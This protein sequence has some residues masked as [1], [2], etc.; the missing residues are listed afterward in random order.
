MSKFIYLLN[1]FEEASESPD[2]ATRG[3]G[4]KRRAL[5]EYVAK[6][7]A[8]VPEE[9]K[10]VALLREALEVLPA[11]GNLRRRIIQTLDGAASMNVS[12]QSEE[13]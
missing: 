5:L 10:L 8:S 2:P 11:R 9:P 1:A 3:Y 4:E 6:L 12:R 7:E 13:K